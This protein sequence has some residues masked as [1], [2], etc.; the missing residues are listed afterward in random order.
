MPS[1]TKAQLLAEVETL[2]KSLEDE[3]AKLRRETATRQA[4]ERTL[5]EAI[6]QQTATAEILRVISGSSGDLQ[7]VL[8]AVAA[9]A[10]RVWGAT[11]AIIMRVEGHD[12]R[13]V[14]HFGPIP[15]VL[16]A[17]R[18]ITS[19]SIAGAILEC[20][21]IHVHDILD[22]DVARDY[23][24]SEAAYRGAG[25]RTTL[26]VPLVREGVAI[27]AITIRRTGVRPFTEKQIKLLETFADQAVIAIENA[28]LFT[29]LQ[30][31]NRA[32]T[33]AHAQVTEALEQ[34]MAT[35]EILRVISS[36]PTDLQP[37]LVARARRHHMHD[38]E[39]H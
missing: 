4:L 25:W 16:P 36:S 13:R 5:T 35:S 23:P 29:E 31:K 28:R 11:D 12:M 30:E 8:D 38:K 3:R 33:D 34:Q 21:P 6:D 26:A 22:T 18:R 39:T 20:R 24:E 2:R 27:G 9:S 10:A 7:R 15:L 14:A 32:L 17:V 19:G 37:V 1:V